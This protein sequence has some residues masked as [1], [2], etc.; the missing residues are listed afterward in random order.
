M[1]FHLIEKPSGDRMD[2]A[3]AHYR[4]RTI[5]SIAIQVKEEN[6][7]PLRN[8]LDLDEIVQMMRAIGLLIENLEDFPLCE[9]AVDDEGFVV[10]MDVR[11]GT[12]FPE[13]LD[14]VNF[15]LLKD[16]DTEED[17]LCTLYSCSIAYVLKE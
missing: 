9:R 13:N 5:R 15:D 10:I 7:Q 14:C 12:P 17:K 6:H 8:R 4:T 2:E 1:M 16:Q 3:V 11:A